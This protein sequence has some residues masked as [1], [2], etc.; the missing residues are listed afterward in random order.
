MR[1]LATEL[2]TGPASL[3]A[4]VVNKDDLGELLIG[5]LCARV[6]LPEPDPA[7]WRDQLAAACAR[8][9]DEYL[10]Y[11]GITRA[12]LAVAPTTSRRCG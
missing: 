10:R 5:R 11:P 4:H 2:E 12:T 3:Y 7:T 9:R 6:E 1:R 8:L